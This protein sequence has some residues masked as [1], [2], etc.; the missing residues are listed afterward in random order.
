MGG[1]STAARLLPKVIP[2][3]HREAMT[4]SHPGHAFRAQPGYNI[5]VLTKNTVPRT[6]FGRQHRQH[7][8]RMIETAVILN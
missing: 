6:N 4:A 1:D 8:Q 3:N 5:S 7:C 2:G